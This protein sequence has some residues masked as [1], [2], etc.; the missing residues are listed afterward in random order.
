VDNNENK[1]LG[2]RPDLS[3]SDKANGVPRVLV[4]DDDFHI[5]KL[6]AGSLS[7]AD[8]R[9]DTAKDGAEAWEA[10]NDAS[11]TLLITDHDMPRMTG[12]ELIRKL[13]SA[14]MALAVVLVSGAMPIEEIERHPAL[15]I[16]AMLAKPFNI[17]EL[18]DTVKKVLEPASA[19]T[20]SDPPELEAASPTVGI[21]QAQVPAI[22]PTREQRKSA[23]RI[24]VVDDDPDLRQLSIDVLRAA[25]YEVEG[26]KD[27]AAGW[28]AVQANNNYDLII[29]DNQMPRMTGIELIEKLRSAHLTPRV[30]MATGNL[31]VHEFA[32]R[33]WLKPDATLERPSTNEDLLVAV[34]NLLPTDNGKGVEK[35]PGNTS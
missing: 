12:F 30:L 3:I 17:L 25:N 13:R 1:S 26:V 35:A 7:G 33:P 23:H 16:R 24:L 9:V 6:I 34:R 21:P 11:Y 15:R 19:Q 20:F 22:S 10:L 5:R 8:Y 14:N 27:G 28:D 18:L 4:V 32:R 2:A 31:P 29:T